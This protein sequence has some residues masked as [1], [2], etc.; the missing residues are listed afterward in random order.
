MWYLNLDRDLT[1]E[2]IKKLINLAKEFKEL[3]D[4]LSKR[5]NSKVLN[6]FIR[7]GITEGSLLD[8]EKV[9]SLVELL[10][11][12]LTDYRVNYKIDENEGGFDIILER[13][14]KLQNVI[15]KIDL[16]FI[17]SYGYTELYKLKNEIDK[18]IGKLPVKV[19]YKNDMVDITDY[20]ELFTKL[21][22]LGK[23]GIEIQRYKGLGE[24]NPEQLWETTMNPKTRRLVQVSL[25]DGA[26][27]DEIFTILMG[28]KVEPRKEFI[29][30]YAREVKNLDV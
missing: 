7:N 19:K 24:M 1:R 9:K 15:N 10:K 22:E 13:E 25:E 4:T 5:V 27:A 14:G 17:S 21:F 11:N 29:M 8:K 3:K 20:E 23:S 12:E 16:D 2:E 28:E 18:L 30:K 6:I 26:L